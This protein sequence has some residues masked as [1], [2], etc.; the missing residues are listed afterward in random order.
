M[1]WSTQDGQSWSKPLSAF[2]DWHQGQSQRSVNVACCPI[3]GSTY[4]HHKGTAPGAETIRY[5]QCVK[6]DKRFKV[7]AATPVTGHI[8]R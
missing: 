8:L 6:C 7:L 3:C 4:V 1:N 5:F 2:D